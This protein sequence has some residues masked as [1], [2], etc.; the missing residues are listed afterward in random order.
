[1]SNPA[2][3]TASH[4]YEELKNA[5]FLCFNAGKK[6]EAFTICCAALKRPQAERKMKLLFAQTIPEKQF[7]LFNPDIKN[8]ILITLQEDGVNYQKLVGAWIKTINKDPSFQSFWSLRGHMLPVA[9]S[10]WP[11]IEA[12]LLDPFLI[13]GLRKFM[14]IQLNLEDLLV[15]LRKRLLL[16]FHP[17]GMLK[18]KHIAFI[19][20]LAELC[21]TNEYLFPVTDEETNA[22]ATLPFDNPIAV[23]I[24]GCYESLEDKNFDEKMLAAVPFKRVV[25]LQ[26]RLPRRRR[27]LAPTIPLVS[28]AQEN[29]SVKVKSM[30]EENPYPRWRFADFPFQPAPDVKADIL[31]AGCGTGKYTSYMGMLFPNARI[32][33]IDI[34]TASIAYAMQKAEEYN[35]QNVTYMQCDIMDVQKLGQTFDYINCSGVLH[36]MADPLEGWRRLLSILALNGAM[37][38]SLYSVLA[39]RSQQTARDFIAEKKFPPTLE[40]IREF[41]KEVRQ[42][43]DPDTLR[44]L[45]KWEDFYTASGTRDLVFH[46]QEKSYTIPELRTML[47]AL[48]LEFLNFIGIDDE[49]VEEYKRLYPQDPAMKILENWD[50]VE[51]L[52]PDM[53]AGM[54]HL[55][56]R[57]QGEPLNPAVSKIFSLGV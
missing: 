34:S 15:G 24:H 47:D 6:K 32:T 1:M 50:S 26:V 10:G 44:S 46:V 41:R 56:C 3:A 43:L 11:I 29:V 7:E 48:G 23:C 45:V 2:P 30:Y 27:E 25:D 8:A 39:R 55:K 49:I 18:N 21:Y 22:L 51:S 4:S 17:K 14:I 37:Y 52:H 13:E 38:I 54:Y 20:A 57:R 35:V 16:E 31:I 36:H 19:G 9:Q 33:A 42:A 5:A 53:F 12:S 28:A 40:G